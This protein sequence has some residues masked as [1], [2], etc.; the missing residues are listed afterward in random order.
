MG[1]AMAWFP[2]WCISEHLCYSW[3]VE[4]KRTRQA[5]YDMNYHLVWCPTH[6]HTAFGEKVP[7]RLEELIRE[8]AG[9][10]EIE[11]IDL[12]TQPD[13]VH[14]FLGGF[15]PTIAP[16]Q[17]IYRLKGYTSRILREAF[18][19]LESRWPSLWTRSPCVGTA[20]HVSAETI[21]RCTEQQKGR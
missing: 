2:C 11:L 7:R 12:A 20:G 10:L 1:K 19:W 15:P 8:K 16:C 4:S 17:M 14:F 21:Q 3:F 18:P 5:T 9:E 6:R 13:P